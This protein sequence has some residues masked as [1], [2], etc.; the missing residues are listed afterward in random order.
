MCPP[1]LIGSTL[2]IL[3]GVQTMMQIGQQNQMAGQ[4]AESAQEAAATDYSILQQRQTQINEQAAL[5][6]FERQRQSLKEQ[7]KIRVAAGEAGVL[8][9]SPLRE[10]ENAMF[11]GAYDKSI[12]ETNRINQIIQAQQA[13]QNVYTQVQSRLNYAESLTT[14]PFLGVLQ[15]GSNIGG[16]FLSGYAI[17]KQLFPPKN[18]LTTGVAINPRVGS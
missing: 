8:G 12:I 2:A 4:I 18:T 6:A 11:Q 14:N 1:L 17:G 3:S 7:A 9:N 15:I 10:V 13:K 5:E 16:S